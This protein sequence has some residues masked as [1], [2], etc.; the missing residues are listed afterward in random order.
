M[1]VM[2]N[3]IKE[4][5][6]RGFIQDITSEELIEL[7]QKPFSVYLGFDSTGDTLHL[8]HL[9]GIIALFWFQRYGH[10]SYALIGGATG[11]I[12]DPSGK[13]IERPFLQDNL[14]DKNAEKITDFL[15]QL[16]ARNCSSKGKQIVFVNN[17]DWLHSV[18][19]IDFLRD[20]GKHFRIGNML[21]KESVK[22]RMLS[23]EGIS[24]TEFSYQVL[25]AY[26]FY[27]LFQH[28]QVLV[29]A[30]GSDQWGNIV[31]GVEL[32]RRKTSKTVYGFTF[33]LLT[34]SDGKKFGKSEEGAVWLDKAKL[35]SYEFYQYLYKVA[36]ADVIFLLKMLTFLPLEEIEALEK[37]MSLPN[38]ETNKAQ[39]I[40]AKEVTLFVHG[41][42]GLKSA[43]QVTEQARP[44][45]ETVLNAQELEQIF[46]RM[47]NAELD[48]EKIIG[49]KIAE[50]IYLAGLVSSKSEAIRLI[51]N[52]G[53]YL[54]NEK[55]SDENY[56]LQEKDLIEKR[57]IVL[58]KGKKNKKI[59]K[60]LS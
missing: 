48:Y 10:T 24:F 17:N 51:K 44:G 15:K 38:Y 54:N 59:I 6:K 45:S 50:L 52:G 55:I 9:V 57:F 56:L 27:H 19:L 49:K 22:L 31:A 3:V 47:P 7:A 41:E 16:F 37:E 35:S 34:K 33:P 21:A 14:I 46:S 58:A 5:K 2:E 29:Q 42:E 53:A 39:K 23:E 60:I 13:S 28:K 20:V 30:G 4:L 43:L 11:R 1:S 12:G 36:D 18:E 26:D 32:V 8:G 40:L 25:Q